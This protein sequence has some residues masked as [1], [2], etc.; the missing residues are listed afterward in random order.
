MK[1]LIIFILSLLLMSPPVLAHSDVVVYENVEHCFE[2]DKVHQEHH[3]QNNCDDEKD[4]EHH[5]HCSL[6]LLALTVFK[7]DEQFFEIKEFKV[8]NTRTNFYQTI[9]YSSYLN[10]VFQPPRFC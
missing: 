5:H 4:T 1:N 6:E 2:T 10:G 3:H 9:Y 7:G 8:K